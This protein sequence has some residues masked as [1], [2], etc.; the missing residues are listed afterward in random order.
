MRANSRI[1]VD[2]L[3]LISC[4]WPLYPRQQGL[5]KNGYQRQTGRRARISSLQSYSMALST[6]E[7]VARALFLAFDE[8]L[9]EGRTRVV[10]LE[11]AGAVTLDTVSR[12][13]VMWP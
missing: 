6:C 4:T 3:A 7:I 11:G 8:R 13:F 5:G 12:R 9:L 2:S 1:M 10:P